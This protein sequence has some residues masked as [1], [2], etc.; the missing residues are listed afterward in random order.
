MGGLMLRTPKGDR[1]RPTQDRVR[2]AVFAMLGAKV[3][4]ARTL[5]LFA[6][7]GALGIEAG[8]RGAASVTWVDEDARSVEVLRE[9]VRLL[10]A[11][12]CEKVVARDEVTRWLRRRTQ[13]G[14]AGFDLVFADPPY[15]WEGWG[16]IFDA[17]GAGVLAEGGIFVAELAAEHPAWTGEGWTILRD[18]A[19]GGT[20]VFLYRKEST[21]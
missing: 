3:A 15:A 11:C 9:N 4:G 8:S 12:D 14:A 16:K 17:L 7:T 6:G 5:D 1:V 21:T 20:R 13:E 10:D 19:Y 18:R 2:E